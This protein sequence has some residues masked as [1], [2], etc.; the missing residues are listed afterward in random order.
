M[1]VAALVMCAFHNHSVRGVTWV[2]LTT[3]FIVVT[4][5]IAEKHVASFDN[6]ILRHI[7]V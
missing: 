1:Q 4:N 3:S 2:R 5:S 6:N 7:K